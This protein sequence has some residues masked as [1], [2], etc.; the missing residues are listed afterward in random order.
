MVNCDRCGCTINREAPAANEQ[1]TFHCFGCADPGKPLA[2]NSKPLCATSGCN[3]ATSGKSKYCRAH[4]VEARAAWLD[5]V[6][7]SAQARDERNEGFSALWGK[8]LAAARKAH[9]EAIPTPM[10]VFD[11]NADGTP[12]VGGDRY[13]VNEGACG[14]GYVTVNPGTSSFARWLVKNAG[15]YK[16]YYGGVRVSTNFG[17]QSIARADAA[18]CAMADVL[19]EAGIKAYASSN[20]D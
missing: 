15:A 12:K 14:F 1:A 20:L 3:S 2:W 17:S 4:K 10:T 8:A 13:Y 5:K 11:A 19:R 16:H 18:A 7:A 6:K 9:A